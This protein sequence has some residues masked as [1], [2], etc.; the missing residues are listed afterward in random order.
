MAD[1]EGIVG[2]NTI[3]MMEVW[4]Q[5]TIKRMQSNLA[6]DKANNTGTLRQSLSDNLGGANI[7]TKKGALRLGITATDY[8]QF[9]DQGRAPGERP[10]IREILKWVQTKLP[11]GG[12]DLSTAFA[13]AKSIQKKGTKGNEFATSVITKK[14]VDQLTKSITEGMREDTIIAINGMIK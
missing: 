8:W 12:N 14:R 6:K 9:V 5:N 3:F 13:I 7:T 1:S 11:S 2:K 10:P 4:T